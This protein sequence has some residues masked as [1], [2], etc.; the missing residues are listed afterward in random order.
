MQYSVCLRLL[1]VYSAAALRPLSEN[2]QIQ[3]FI[4][5]RHAISHVHALSRDAGR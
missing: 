2:V 4:F 1:D 3:P 5:A